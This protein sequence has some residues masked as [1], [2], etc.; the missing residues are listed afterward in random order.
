MAEALRPVAMAGRGPTASRRGLWTGP[1]SDVLAGLLPAFLLAALVALPLA[2]VAIA[3]VT[4]ALHADAWTELWQRPQWPKALLMTLWTGVAAT[5]ISLAASAWLLSRLMG[6]PAW[7][8]LVRSLGPMLAVPHAAFAIGLAL[9][10]APTGWLLRLLSPWA[11]GAHAP[12]PWP[13][14]QDPL[15][16]GLIAVLVAK[17]V[18]F[19][20][21][22]AASQ[23]QRQD[24]GARLLRE[25]GLARTFGYAQTT[26]WWRVVWPQLWPRLWAPLLAVLAYSL[27]VV[28]MALIIGPLAPPTL[29]VLAWQWLLD[30][31]PATNATGACAAWTLALLVAGL[32][33]LAW[34][35]P[36]VL[37]WR[38]RW[39][40]GQRGR[41]P[42]ASR[43][44]HG[45][46]P[47]QTRGTAQAWAPPWPWL[48]AL[49]LYA[50]VLLA[51]LFA[52][53]AGPWPF[54]DL[55]PRTL[56][57]AAWASVADSAR[58]L[59]LTL[60]LGMASSLTALVWALAWLESAPPAWDRAMRRLLWLPL[61]L[62]PVLW[63][64][65]L[66]GLMLRAGLD[67]RIGGLWLAHTLAVLPYTLIALSPA[68]LAFDPRHAQVA[69]SLGH[70]RATF[71]LR[72]KWPLLRAVLAS[73]L[74]VGFAVSVAQ[75][76]P[77]LF[78][79]AGRFNTITTEAVTLASDGQR[80]LASA[81]AWLQWLLPA[82]GF[83][84]AAWAG[85]P[86]RFRR[87]ARS[88]AA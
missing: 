64:V 72:V 15:G 14:V 70:P 36:R 71:L 11:T 56:S 49:A 77:T 54:P 32:A 79:G 45:P 65:G 51:L 53:I 28:D 63:I 20:L 38:R 12:P 82:V 50:A 18:P 25:L 24:T 6:T 27:T 47:S 37:R 61:L 35:L 9:L 10:V 42:R 33:A 85:Q 80:S 44:G 88:A 60:G 81:H 40:S 74:A 8:T 62:P 13:T 83:A 2:G 66:H 1:L 4:S 86:R 22:T 39:T 69:A 31:D 84:L 17:E 21:W 3:A 57:S 58:T 23:L 76:L 59:G 67:G 16:L 34:P 87:A 55:W 68:Y 73:A 30:A 19:L 75:Y 29:S 78:I 48:A 26:A 46:V 43:P 7:Q 5:T 41:E 52:S